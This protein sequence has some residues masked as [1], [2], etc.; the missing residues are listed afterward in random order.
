M[1]LSELL[2]KV[3]YYFIKTAYINVPKEIYEVV[4]SYVFDRAVNYHNQ[5]FENMKSDDKYTE[6]KEHLINNEISDWRNPSSGIITSLEEDKLRI[7]IP[8]EL[9][10]YYNSMTEE[11]F[12]KYFAQKYI[13]TGEEIPENIKEYKNLKFISLLLYAPV[14]DASTNPY[15]RPMII[16]K[17]FTIGEIKIPINLSKFSNLKKDLEEIKTKIIHELT[18]SIQDYISI[19]TN[20]RNGLISNTGLPSQK[21]RDL[22]L[23]PKGKVNQEDKCKKCG[24]NLE[25]MDKSCKECGTITNVGKTFY[26]Y[27]VPYVNKDNKCKEC[28]ADIGEKDIS[29]KEC[30]ATTDVGEFYQLQKKHIKKFEDSGRITHHHQDIEYYTLVRDLATYYFPKIVNKLPAALHTEAFSTFVGNKSVNDFVAKVEELKSNNSISESEAD[31][32]FDMS[33]NIPYPSLVSWKSINPEKWKL[34]VKEIYKIINNPSIIRP[35]IDYSE[36]NKKL[37]SNQNIGWSI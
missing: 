18:H 24:N 12:N 5:I 31:F 33:D 17:T 20:K 29:C 26:K 1:K 36:E 10:P 4:K 8:L 13:E 28:N 22:S 32:A 9:M 16:D 23:D 21:V 2:A 34:A 19:I 14:K 30:G 37:P 35:D 7:T 27:V 25:K 6:L 15:Y 3:E 11:H